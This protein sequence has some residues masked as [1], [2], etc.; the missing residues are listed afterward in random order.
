MAHD[1][2]ALPPDGAGKK[3]HTHSLNFNGDITHNQIMTIGDPEFSDRLQYVDE[4]GA[5]YVRFSEGNQIFDAFGKSKVS[6]ETIVGSYVPT[7]GLSDETA[8]VVNGTAGYVHLPDES[9]L[10]LSVGTASGDKIQMTTHKYHKFF[11]GTSQLIEITGVVGD[12]GKTNV[13]RQWGYY[14]DDNGVIFAMHGTN[15]GII[16]RSSVTG[17]PVDTFI[18]QSSFNKDKA[19]GT[20]ISNFLMDPTKVN[21]YWIDFQWTGRIRV[22]GFSPAGTRVVFH[23]IENAN[24][25]AYPSMGQSSLPLRVEMF[26]SGISASSSEMKVISAMVYTESN[27]LDFRGKCFS[28]APFNGAPIVPTVT[29]V[30]NAFSTS[31]SIRPKALLAGKINRKAIIPSNLMVHTD[32][33]LQLSIMFNITL[34]GTETWYPVHANSAVEKCPGGV[35]VDLGTQDSHYCELIPAGTSAI[36]L[37]KSFHYLR[38]YLKNNAD[39]SQ[40]KYSIVF[41]SIDGTSATV[42]A[43]MTWTELDI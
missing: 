6:Q 31:V 3:L 20:G 15:F 28:T 8:G 23:E 18:P 9:A 12:F 19:D 41:R 16:L 29:P 1:F 30:G 42:V 33:A 34:D 2:I 32:K 13:I 26:N 24:S 4:Y 27:N 43:G 14:D 37:E 5:A 22:G 36:D 39:G 17:S 35:I 38:K 40:P 11:P 25:S 10:R 21:T 7:Y